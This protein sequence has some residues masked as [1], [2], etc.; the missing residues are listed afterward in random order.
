MLEKQNASYAS[1][2]ANFP[3]FTKIFKENLDMKRKIKKLEADLAELQR[4]KEDL[5]I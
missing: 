2:V 3:A 5:C 1:M 4:S